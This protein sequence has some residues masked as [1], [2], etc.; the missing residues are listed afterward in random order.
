[1]ARGGWCRDPENARSR[2]GIGVFL[3]FFSVFFFVTGRTNE[4]GAI[5]GERESL[6]GGGRDPAEGARVGGDR[7][8]HDLGRCCARKRRKVV[9]AW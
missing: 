6:R 9:A 7:R 2:E 4:G 8:A 5:P 1:M 3:F